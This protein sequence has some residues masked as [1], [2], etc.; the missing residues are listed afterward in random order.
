MKPVKSFASLIFLIAFIASCQDSKKSNLT[1]FSEQIPTAIPLVFG[2]GII[3]ID[4]A[5]DFAITFNPEMDELFF[6][7]RK[8]GE[9]NN[10]YTMKLADGKWSVPA[11]ASFSSNFIL[12]TNFL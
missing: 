11:L 2:S 12:K 3:S 7:R 9:K 1:L 6:T 8:D 5:I 10:I 4:D